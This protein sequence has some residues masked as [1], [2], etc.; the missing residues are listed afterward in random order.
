MCIIV[1]VEITAIS[2]SDRQAIAGEQY[3]LQCSLLGLDRA[4]VTISSE[5]QWIGPSNNILLMGSQNEIT[6]SELGKKLQFHR[7]NNS[8]HSGTYICQVTITGGTTTTVT[9]NA[10]YHLQIT[11]KK[12]IV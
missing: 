2:E 1:N 11:C 9:V 8:T 7:L 4:V 3:D 6:I 5:F 10:S 12:C